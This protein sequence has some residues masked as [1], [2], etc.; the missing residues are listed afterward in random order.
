[1]VKE[2]VA[3]ELRSA[4]VA[5]KKER[6]EIDDQIDLMEGTLS[7]LGV[8]KGKASKKKAGRKKSATRK[9]RGTKKRAT[10][11]KAA[12]KKATKKK[13]TQK[14][15]S[16]KKVTKKKAGKKKKPYWSP[17]ARAAARERMRKYWADRNKG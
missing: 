2:R 1:M 5:L 12:K 7:K 17:A 15:A 14:K 8:S 16:K 9:K 10:K 11:A 6:D 4:L 13:A 3:N